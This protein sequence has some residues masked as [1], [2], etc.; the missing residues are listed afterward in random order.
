MNA[1][2]IAPG[3][4]VLVTGATGFTG[5]VLVRK[6]AAAGLRIQAIARASSN[7]QPLAD[8][9]IRWFRGEVYDPALVTEAAREARYIFHLATAYREA[10]HA[11]E[12]YRR[13]HLLSTQLLAQA[14]L[15]NQGFQRFVHISTVGVMG[16]IAQPPADETAPLNP[17]DIYQATKAEAEV[18]LRDFA[19]QAGLPIS[20]LRPAAIYGPGDR[21]LLKFFRMASRRWLILLGRGPG[22][23]HLIHVDDLTEII[24]LA[25]THPAALNEVFI[26]G[27]PQCVTLEEMARV[28]AATLG[29]HFRVVH[30]PAAPFFLAADICEGL[31]RKVGL[32]PPIHR[33]RLAFFTKDRSFDTRK[34]RTRLGYQVRHSNT[35][36]LAEVTRWYSAQGWLP[37]VSTS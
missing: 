13:V 29:R 31:C 35:S 26:C 4:T 23:Y 20:V 6:L 22:L 24:M 3:T 16:H 17:G 14:A 37:P 27:N 12:V 33:R 7:L 19:A 28:V 25:A 8:L 1:P 11:D 9:D 2:T 30:L 18:W 5:T 32:E 36:G 34:L 10:K 15:A 21:R